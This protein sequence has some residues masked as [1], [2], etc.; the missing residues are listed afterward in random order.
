MAIDRLR[1]NIKQIREANG[2]TQQELS[3]LTGF[4]QSQI[5]RWETSENPS[6]KAMTKIAIALD[7][8]IDELI[9]QGV[10]K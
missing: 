7:V 8:S 1:N 2:M 5:S 10:T 4:T 3:K 9:Y 6:L